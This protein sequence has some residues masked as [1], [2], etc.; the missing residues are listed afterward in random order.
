MKNKLKNMRIGKKL[1]IVF[2][3]IIAL[4]IICIGVATF[5]LQNIGG[6]LS[7]FY[8][9]S[10]SVVKNQLMMRRSIQSAVKNILWSCTAEDEAKTKEHLESAESDL[11][12]ANEI[13]P[14]LK[15]KY[16]SDNDYL[17]KAEEKLVSS[18]ELKVKVME[19]ATQNKVTESLETFNNEYAPLIVEA[20]SYL[21]KV[22]DYAEEQAKKA[23]SSSQTVKIITI[24]LLIVV[25]V[26]SLLITIYLCLMITRSITS[27]IQEIESAA[28]ALSDGILD[29]SITYE[30]KDELGVLADSM[31]I[32]M[33][34]M[35][36][37][38]R[39]IQYCLDAMADGNFNIKT[40]AEKNYI[41]DFSPILRAIRNINTKLSGTIGQIKEA[42]S[43]VTA[44]SSQ[45]AEGAQTLAEGATDQAGA[46]EELLATIS[47]VTS[48]VETNAKGAKEAADKAQN[49]GLSIENSNDSMKMMTEAM[50]KISETSGQIELIIKTIEDIASQTNLLSLNAA[51]EAARA[52]EA[53][54]GFAV[55]AD[56]IRELASQSAQAATNTRQLIESSI[57]EVDNG[58][59]IADETAKA[60]NEVIGG[61]Q[62]IVVVAD[63]VKNSSMQQADSMKQVN[64]GI[65]QIS[66]VVQSN[67]ATAEESSA[68]SEELSAQAESLNELVSQFTLKKI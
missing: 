26:V 27:P 55:V 11:N 57:Q 3:I 34:G 12:E 22:G 31:R 17:T 52:G 33:D 10:Y 4:F 15:E 49:V 65:E 62:E 7:D 43:Q 45:M 46:V 14:V 68:T 58:N 39:D 30:S 5:S 13:L 25:A 32:T 60:L 16:K 61:V 9:E 38:I 59:R 19:L 44:G 47:E 35:G 41:G 2:G 64:D 42:A 54:K 20:Q 29:S 51:I 63:D 18:K 8:N 6:K 24:V 56:E 48:Q 23:Y 66:T 50:T 28:K 40:K 36:A 67:S 53:G 1:L 21:Q 37:I